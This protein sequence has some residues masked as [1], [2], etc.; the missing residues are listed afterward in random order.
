MDADLNDRR[1]KIKMMSRMAKKRHH[2]GWTLEAPGLSEQV[3]LDFE[4]EL[5]EKIP[6]EMALAGEDPDFQNKQSLCTLCEHRV[7]RMVAKELEKRNSPVR[8]VRAPDGD[9][10]YDFVLV[11]KDEPDA[12]L[13]G[14]VPNFASKALGRGGQMKTSAGMVCGTEIRSMKASKMSGQYGE[15]LFKHYDYDLGRLM[16]AENGREYAEDMAVDSTHERRSDIASN[17]KLSKDDDEQLPVTEM[18]RFDPSHPDGERAW[19]KYGCEDMDEVVSKLQSYFENS[20]EKKTFAE[21]FT[22]REARA[23]MSLQELTGLVVQITSIPKQIVDAMIHVGASRPS[24]SQFKDHATPHSKSSYLMAPKPHYDKDLFDSWISSIWDNDLDRIEGFFAFTNQ[25]LFR[26]RCFPG[27]TK[28][29]HK[30]ENCTTQLPVINERMQNIIIHSISGVL[31]LPGVEPASASISPEQR[32]F[33]EE[34]AAYYF[35]LSYDDDGELLSLDGADK[36]RLLAILRRSIEPLKEDEDGLVPIEEVSMTLEKLFKMGMKQNNLAY[37]GDSKDHEYVGTNRGAA[38]AK[39]TY[40]GL[41]CGLPGWRILVKLKKGKKKVNSVKDLEYHFFFP[42]DY[43]REKG[44]PMS[45]IFKQHPYGSGA[46]GLKIALAMAEVYEK[47]EEEALEAAIDA[48]GVDHDVVDEIVRFQGTAMSRARYRDLLA[49]P[50]AVYSET[51]VTQM[52]E[53]RSL[54][55]RDHEPPDRFADGQERLK[56]QDLKQ[57]KRANEHRREAYAKKKHKEE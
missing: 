26:H 1:L 24:G 29:R 19:N 16:L 20:K 57:K 40:E 49:L 52:M 5:A 46:E 15:G 38:R 43:F 51:K 33:S 12:I 42:P 27:Q 13:E 17:N 53:P 48:K 7:L 55:R 18:L 4:E 22:T 8:L 2:G 9:P 35:K 14:G 31:E 37:T 23:M 50:T 30:K 6:I 32:Q 3:R 34:A 47:G 11:S 39:S 10:R 21:L 44:K 54:P 36:Q 25:F 28:Q 41:P 56:A 45:R